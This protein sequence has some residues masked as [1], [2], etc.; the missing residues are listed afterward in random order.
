MYIFLTERKNYDKIRLTIDYHK[1]GGSLWH[2]LHE[3][4]KENS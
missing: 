1:N 3:N 4:L 2:I